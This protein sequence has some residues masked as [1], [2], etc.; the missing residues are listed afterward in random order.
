[1]TTD[2]YAGV[3]VDT[4]VLSYVLSPEPHGMR[5]AERYRPRLEGRAVAISFQTEGELRVSLATQHLDV[6]QFN[7]LIAD[8]EVIE[9]SSELLDCYVQ[10]RAASIE[11]QRAGEGRKIDAADGWVAATALLLDRPL[12]TH[13]LK[14]STSLSGYPL[15]KVITELDS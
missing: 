7:A 10:A 3:V 14:L 4:N 13:D 5:L 6:R 1:M 15:I 2:R 9:W 11:R 12:V 8:I